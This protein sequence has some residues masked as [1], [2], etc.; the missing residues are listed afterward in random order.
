M[1]TIGL[2]KIEQRA[3]DVSGELATLVHGI[4]FAGDDPEMALA[5]WNELAHY[6]HVIQRTIQAQAAARAFPTMCRPLGGRVMTPRVAESAE[7][8]AGEREL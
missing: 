4:C 1:P 3:L 5:D 2:T 6:I 8:N 7:F